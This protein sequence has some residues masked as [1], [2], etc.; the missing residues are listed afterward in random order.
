MIFDVI[1]HSVLEIKTI[2][3]DLNGTL[4]IDGKLIDGIRERIDFLK[5]AGLEFRIFSGDTQGTGSAI[6]DTLGVQLHITVDGKAKRA[7][8]EKLGST[9]TAAIGNG[10]IDRL[11]FQTAAL[12]ICVLQEEGAFGPLLA[13]ADIVVRSILDALDLFRYPKR[14]IATLRN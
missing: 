4:T 5:E 14:L 13:E 7:E 11:L 6:A 9:H 8:V 10:Q 1:G 3:L 2:V 12:S